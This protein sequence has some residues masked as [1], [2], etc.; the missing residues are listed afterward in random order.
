MA[1]RC[2][3]GPRIQCCGSARGSLAVS[4]KNISPCS[5]PKMLICVRLSQKTSIRSITMLFVVGAVVLNTL[6]TAVL[7]QA[8]MANYPGGVALTRLN[9]LYSDSTDGASPSVLIGVLIRHSEHSPRPYLQPRCPD[10]GVSLPA[11]TSGTQYFYSPTLLGKR[12][13][14]FMDV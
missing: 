6:G 10:R 14:P 9:F 1:L 12:R 13:E 4:V 5:L 8:S 11:N 7:T 2:V 3:C